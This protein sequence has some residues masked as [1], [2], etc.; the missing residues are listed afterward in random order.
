MLRI[1]ASEKVINGTLRPVNQTSER[2]SATARH[3]LCGIER[4]PGRTTIPVLLGPL[5]LVQSENRALGM[6]YDLFRHRA[7]EDVGKAGATV[8][9]QDDQVGLLLFRHADD[10]GRR[11][12]SHHPHSR[13]CIMTEPL[14]A[15][16]L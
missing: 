6:A 10:L 5:S 7:E 12:A 1:G 2:R 16:L 9:G 4:Q 8:R 15:Q 14:F 3:G 13:L 11:V